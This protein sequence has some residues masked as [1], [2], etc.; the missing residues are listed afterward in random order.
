MIYFKKVKQN[1][2]KLFF[3]TIIGTF[4]IYIVSAQDNYVGKY[5]VATIMKEKATPC[6]DVQYCVMKILKDSV[7][8]NFP[9][10]TYCIENEQK[11]D[12]ITFNKQLSKKF[13]WILINDKLQIPEFKEFNNYIFEEKDADIIKLWFSQS[14]D[15]SADKLVYCKYLSGK[16]SMLI[17]DIERKVAEKWGIVMEYITGDCTDKYDYRQ[18]ECD[19]K[20]KKLHEFMNQKYGKNWLVKFEK[21]VADEIKSFSSSK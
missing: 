21:V 9:I 7:E 19:I 12:S 20:N 1:I 16:P 13:K 10:K 15:K 11:K 5:Y 6:F 8:V 3:L 18:K 17:I 14:T 2:V 4:N